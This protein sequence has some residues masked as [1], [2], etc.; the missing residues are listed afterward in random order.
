MIYT[1]IDGSSNS[2]NQLLELLSVVSNPKVYEE[3]VLTLQK[4]IED[5]KKYI[6]LVGPAND[7]IVLRNR[8]VEELE[9]AKT[10]VKEA[11]SKANDIV[12]KAKVTAEDLV[13]EAKSTA[14][15][16]V[17][18]ASV[19]KEQAAQL[20]AKVQKL[21]E[22]A[23]KAQAEAVINASQASD[24]AAELEEALNAAKQ[25]KLAANELRKELIKKHTDFI[26]SL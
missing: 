22:E 5:N 9:K 14:K 4:A 1:N 25:A 26:K 10:E 24:T 18:E 15:A 8:T 16:L 3:K 21:Q 17:E 2:S 23:S 7:I 6:E 20:T 11:K 12:A 13:A 19:A